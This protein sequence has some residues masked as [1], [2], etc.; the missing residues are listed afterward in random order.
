[1][2]SPLQISLTTA[3]GR[4]NLEAL[5]GTMLLAFMVEHLLA[6]LML[7]WPEA[8]PYQWYTNTL[9]RSILVRGLEVALFALFIVHIGIGLHMRV[10]HRRLLA[11]HPEAPRPKAVSTRFVGWTGLII[12]V[13]LV[14]HLWRF[15]VPN[16][17]Q[18]IEGFDLY[19][20]AHLA[21]ADPW[22]T[23]IYVLSMVALASHLRH[24]IRSALFSFRFIPKPML[25]R[26]RSVLS[27]IGFASS[28]GLA[29]IAAH[30][31]VLSVIR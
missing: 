26:V 22:Y 15:F 19:Q 29:Y 12:L 9:G 30:L 1:M 2:K 20:Q 25:P 31:Y 4:K 13:F 11:R 24:G 17:I 27:W 6:N 10:Q 7:L 28:L 16:R 18:Q 21:F 3:Y 23:L 5:S 14:I 8:A